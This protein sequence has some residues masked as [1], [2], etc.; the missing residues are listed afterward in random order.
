M[1]K[2]THD[3]PAR[4]KNDPMTTANKT[5]AV[6]QESQIFYICFNAATF[7]MLHELCKIVS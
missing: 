6:V 1:P 2:N 5:E 7:K 4:S 3:F